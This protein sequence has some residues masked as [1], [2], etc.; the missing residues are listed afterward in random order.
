[1]SI[2]KL[3]LAVITAAFVNTAS[4][5]QFTHAFASAPPLNWAGKSGALSVIL[6]FEQGKDSIYGRGAYTVATSGRVGCGGETLAPSGYFTM[7][8][9][10]NAKAFRGRFLFD[11]GWMPPVSAIQSAGG[12]IK[13][14]IRS[15]DRGSCPLTL[16]RSSQ[17]NPAIRH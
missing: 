14:S 2:F 3:T 1:M 6:T 16:R 9:K 11:S 15:V 7:R 5:T 10:G 12:D 17:R 4:P 13:V 8:A